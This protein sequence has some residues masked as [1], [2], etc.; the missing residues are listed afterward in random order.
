MA[1]C[2]YGYFNLLNA[3]ATPEQARS[4]LPNSL[5]TE[6]N[7]TANVREWRNFFTLRCDKA[8]HPQMREVAIPLLKEFA[9]KLPVLFGDLV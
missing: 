3:G 6:I 9:E 5:K 1:A 8:A 7:M 4:V 2:E